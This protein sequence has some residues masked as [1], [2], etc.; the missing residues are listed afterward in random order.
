ML[1]LEEHRIAYEREQKKTYSR[2]Q[3]HEAV[4]K[5]MET[6]IDKILGTTTSSYRGAWTDSSETY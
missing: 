6:P 2:C 3:G 1:S 4:K 5:E